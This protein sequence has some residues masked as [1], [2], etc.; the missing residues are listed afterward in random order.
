MNSL[1]IRGAEAILTGLAGEASRSEARDI[2]IEGG[3]I[4]D[5]GR[6][7]PLPGERQLD[8]S[9]CVVYPGWV[10]T[11]HHLFQTLMKGVPGAVNAPLPEW[12][13]RVPWALRKNLDAEALEVSALVGIAELLL[14]GC[15][16]VADHHYVYY[17]G[18]SFDSGAIVFEVAE[19]LG[20]RLV[21]CRGG[22][23]LPLFGQ[24]GADWLAPETPEAML[25]DTERL[26]GRFHDKSEHARQRVA[27]A[28]TTPGHRIRRE[29]MRDFAAAARRMGIRLHTHLSEDAPYIDWCLEKYG[30]RPVHLCAEEDWIGEDVWF[31][32]MCHLDSS[33]IALLGQTRTGI[34]HCP[35]SN[36]RLGSGVSPA[37]A[38]A[39]AGATVSLAVDGTASNETGDMLS[40]VHLALYL[41]RAVNARVALSAEDAVSWGTQGGARVLGLK[42]GV[43]APGY[44]AD[45]S[46][47]S[48]E[49][50]RYFG[51]HDAALAPVLGGGRP[52]LKWVLC[53][54]R[55]VV[56]DGR[57]PGLDLTE[58][59]GRARRAIEKLRI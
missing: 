16:T 54:G 49:D 42:T 36:C 10:C 27:L 55:T 53:G 6:L 47:Y 24:E 31:A 28:P 43:L 19:R 59:A 46:V 34:A 44:A 13:Q 41:H 32:H 4:R 50:P 7:Q 40:E 8:A 29:D 20:V 25:A 5:V 38:L 22:S 26:V 2:R 3:L 15:T 23:T 52:H 33:E 1:L 51:F 39:A 21:L 57:I 37:P 18:M 48:L 14:G 30:K 56:E 45:L 9:G 35:G 12:L 58:L 17:P 11:H